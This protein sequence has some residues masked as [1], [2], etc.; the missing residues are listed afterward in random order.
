MGALRFNVPRPDSAW[1]RAFVGHWL[2]CRLRSNDNLGWH[3]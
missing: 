1:A 2:D 3:Q